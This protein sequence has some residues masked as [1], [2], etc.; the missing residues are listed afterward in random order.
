[1]ATITINDLPACRRLDLQAMSSRRGGG[2]PWVFGWI[3]PHVANPGF[4]AGVVNFFQI[5]NYQ[6]GQMNNQ[7]QIVDI[8]NS[9]ANARINVQL[10]ESASNSAQPGGL[11]A[12]R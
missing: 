3:R 11:L 1:M 8:T 6:V 9:A 2:A 12:S 7:I 5:N 10:A 4:G